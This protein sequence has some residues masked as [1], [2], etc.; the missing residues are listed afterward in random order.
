MLLIRIDMLYLPLGRSLLFW[1]CAVSVALSIA[2]RVS[3]SK[4]VHGGLLLP[5]LLQQ[6][7]QPVYLFMNVRLLSLFYSHEVLH[8]LIL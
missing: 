3:R 8:L 2:Y 7:V 4:I 1:F 5:L 6:F